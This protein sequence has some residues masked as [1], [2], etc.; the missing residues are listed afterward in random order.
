MRSTRPGTTTLA[1]V[2]V[3][4]AASL[5]AA[6]APPEPAFLGWAR[7]PPMGWN[8]WDAFGTTITEAQVKAQAD[9]MAEKLLPFG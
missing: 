3:S 2:F 9:V 4:L 5:A 8:S 1:M 6:A 7:T